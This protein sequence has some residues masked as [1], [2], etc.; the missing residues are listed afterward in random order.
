LQTRI[1][2]MKWLTQA[3]S[4]CGKLKN[5]SDVAPQRSTYYGLPVTTQAAGLIVSVILSLSSVVQ[6][7]GHVRVAS[8]PS[9]TH[10]GASHRSRRRSST[11][12]PETRTHSCR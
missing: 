4:D 5:L 12:R 8:V 3:S 7:A 11:H 2:A 9:Y 10:P 1:K 6:A